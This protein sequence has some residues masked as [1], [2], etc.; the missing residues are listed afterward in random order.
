MTSGR[1]ARGRGGHRRK[2]A[3]A[4][5][6]V[7]GVR[8][9]RL[10]KILALAGFGSRRSVEEYLRQGRVTVNGKI[11]KLGDSADPSHDVVDLD[12][13]RVTSQALAYW[14]VHKP[15]GVLSTLRDDEGRRTV[16]DLLPAGV[17][18]VY[19]V[20]RLDWDTSGLLLLTNDG[21]LT[22]VLLHPS[23]GNEREYS[24]TVKGDF[25][26]KVQRRLARGIRLEDGVT[27][28]AV[29]SNVHCDSDAGT[30]RFSLTI[31]EGRK[32][33]IRRSLLAMGH[34]VKKLVRV[35]MGPLRLGRLKR[36]SARPLRED[37]VRALH[38]HAAAL[39]HSAA[40]VNRR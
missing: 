3:A 22:H 37:E 32:H 21:A 27:A 17:P 29:V 36:G 11:A 39:Q 33:Q 7:P 26:E 6:G 28:P 18:R 38:A 1:A 8:P 35:R 40:S 10:Q 4:A 23:L 20:G 19:P 14:M 34:P 12:G 31:S 9:V 2:T 15:T 5:R 16:V 13:E 24:V 25:P 30:S